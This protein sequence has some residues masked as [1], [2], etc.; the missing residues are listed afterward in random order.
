MLTCTNIAHAYADR[1]PKKQ[2][3][4]THGGTHTNKHVHIYGQCTHISTHKNKCVYEHT[5]RKK[6]KTKPKKE[7][8][9]TAH[10]HNIYT[11]TY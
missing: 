5:D 9:C 7:I 8:T 3:T 11:Y 6:K 10:T 1:K 2:W 4:Q